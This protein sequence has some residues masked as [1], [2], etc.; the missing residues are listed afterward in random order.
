MSE[1][2]LIAFGVLTVWAGIMVVNIMLR[3]RTS[4]G[5]ADRPLR[6]IAVLMVGAVYAGFV[7][8]R[9]VW[10]EAQFF[11]LFAAVALMVII[12]SG[13]RSISSIWAWFKRWQ[14]QRDKTK[15]G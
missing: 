8:G 5:E 1:E 6:I 2:T 9:M 10:P 13:Q 15:P 14:E 11:L 7:F 12:Q 4:L 3:F